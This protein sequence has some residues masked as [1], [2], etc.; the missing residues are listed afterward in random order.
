MLEKLGVLF[1]GI[2]VF[3]LTFLLIVMYNE[4]RNRKSNNIKRNES[5]NI[6]RPIVIETVKEVDALNIQGKIIFNN[7]KDMEDYKET[8]KEKVFSK[9]IDKLFTCSDFSYDQVD[10]DEVKVIVD[11]YINSNVNT[12]LNN[13][14]PKT[15]INVEK[16]ENINKTT[17][18]TDSIMNV[19]L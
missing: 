4:R 12:K 18:I 11:S 16:K 10:C 17:D 8:V 5:L 6:L 13:P 1:L 9:V 15:S 19:Y 7:I 14:I 2:I 3:D